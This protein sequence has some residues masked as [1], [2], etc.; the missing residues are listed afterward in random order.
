MSNK[1][2]YYKKTDLISYSILKEY[3]SNPKKA[4]DMFIRGY[5]NN[6]KHVYNENFA[7]GDAIELVYTTGLLPLYT[8]KLLTSQN[9]TAA[10]GFL[11]FIESRGIKY[12]HNIK[13][14]INELND[15][16]IS[17]LYN[18]L[19]ADLSIWG[20][21]S[22]S[23]TL[24]KKL[25]NI[26]DLISIINSG[27]ILIDYKFKTIIDNIKY[28]KN[29]YK[30]PLKSKKSIFND[31]NIH[32]YTNVE[33]IHNGN[34]ILL[35]MIAYDESDN[36]LY[37]FDIKSSINTPDKF[38]YDFIKYKYY[39]QSSFY[40]YNI[41]ELFKNNKIGLKL[42]S[43]TLSG[44]SIITNK[45]TDFNIPSDVKIL[46]FRFILISKIE[47]LNPVVFRVNKKLHDIGLTGGVDDYGNKIYGALELKSKFLMALNDENYN[48]HEYYTVDERADLD[49]N[50][51]KSYTPIITSNNN[52]EEDI[53]DIKV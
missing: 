16:N 38:K 4:V 36:T 49:L 11:E 42:K 52:S 6:N 30:L 34:K 33:I 44:L 10:V 19:L 20:N 48:N 35:D 43:I 1:K 23:D 14:I 3:E 27:K 25:I 15:E 39:L 46:D 31:D 40:K 13:Q 53:S 41:E 24:I 22:K 9:Y 5:G 8:D 26:S 7:L 28:L 45:I 51:F 2:N 29:S 18:Y 21:I 37:P 32:V 50:V 12:R 47:G 17:S